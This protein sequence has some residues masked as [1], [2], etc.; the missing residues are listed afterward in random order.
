MNVRLWL[1]AD[2]GVAVDYCA[3]ACSVALLSKSIVTG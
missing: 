3:Y 2:I 1:K